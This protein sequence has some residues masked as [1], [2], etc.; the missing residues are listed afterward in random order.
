MDVFDLERYALEDGPGIRTVVFLKGCNLRCAW[1]QN[2][3]SQEQRPQVMYYRQQC[4]SCERCVQ[5]CPTRSIS[6]VDPYGYITNHESCI[7]CGACVEACYYD[8]RKIIGEKRSVEDL[9]KEILKDKPFF[10]E[11]GGGVTF[12]GGEPLLQNKELLTLLTLLREEGVHTVV[13]T[14]GY[15]RWSVFQE[16]LSA[17]DMFFIDLK[18][19]DSSEHERY[20]G[21]PNRLILENITRLSRSHPHVVVRIPVVPGVNNS[22]AIM[23]RMFLFLAR[24]TSISNVQLLPFHRLGLNKYSGLGRHYDMGKTE[25]LSKQDCESLAELGKR[26]GLDVKVGAD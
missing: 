18:H 22:E 20:N 25:N 14:A 9:L 15:V 2:P 16:L 5:A 11:S 12:S 17:V 26:L 8:A 1:C 23:E 19:I 24:E 21:V 3:E 13:E 7:L 10:D 4:T 6:R